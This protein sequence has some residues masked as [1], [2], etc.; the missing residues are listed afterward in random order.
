V[1]KRTRWLFVATSKG[2]SAYVLQKNRLAR[3]WTK[4]TGGTSP[5]VAGGLL[6]VYD[7]YEGALNVYAPTTGRSV[8]SL[9]VG[10]GHWNTPV[11]TDGRIA[12]GQ[13][14]ANAHVT[15]GVLNIYRLP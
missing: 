7:S 5:V 10:R 2:T 13:E 1:S 14:D 3:K 8:A 15:F 12:L 9:P 4:T 6:Y 11:V